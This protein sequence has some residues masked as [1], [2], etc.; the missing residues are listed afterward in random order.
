MII[1]TDFSMIHC[2]AVEFTDRATRLLSSRRKPLIEVK[3]PNLVD[4]VAI[5]SVNTVSI[6]PG[7]VAEVS[8]TYKGKLNGRYKTKFNSLL[9]QKYPNLRTTAID[10]NANDIPEECPQAFSWIIY[11]HDPDNWINIKKGLVIAFAE[12]RDEEICEIHEVTTLGECRNWM[13]A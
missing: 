4:A 6:Q 1:G 7:E 13:P 10:I 8:V 2:M 9:Q 3:I 12:K 11:N 5:T